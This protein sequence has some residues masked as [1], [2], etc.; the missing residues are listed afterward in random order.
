VTKKLGIDARPLS[1]KEET[2]TGTIQRGETR[3]KACASQILRTIRIPGFE[4]SS[5]WLEK[6]M[7]KQGYSSAETE[8]TLDLLVLRHVLKK[9]DNGVCMS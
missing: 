2:L 8:E 7:A 5:G 1:S 9:T 6:E 3:V 4:Y